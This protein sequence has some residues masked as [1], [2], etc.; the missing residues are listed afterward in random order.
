MMI[1]QGALHAYS[2]MIRVPNSA[3][4]YGKLAPGQLMNMSDRGI[5][6]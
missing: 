6:R 2:E 3:M 5:W 1:W 4:E